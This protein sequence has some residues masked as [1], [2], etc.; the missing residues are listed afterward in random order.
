[1][2]SWLAYMRR[3]RMRAC[4]WFELET[5]D[6]LIGWYHRANFNQLNPG[7]KP[8]SFISTS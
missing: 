4:S 8:S 2:G 7:V 1:M 5:L 3:W 6:D